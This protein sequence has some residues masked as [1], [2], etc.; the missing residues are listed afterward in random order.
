M[1]V[2]AQVHLKM[3]GVFMIKSFKVVP[4]LMSLWE[5]LGGHVCKMLDP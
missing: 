3:A 4:S 1:H 2:P 5:W